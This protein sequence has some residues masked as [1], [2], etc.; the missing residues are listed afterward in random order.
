MPSES[1][2]VELVLLEQYRA[3]LTRIAA[4]RFVGRIAFLFVI[5]FAVAL[6][7]Q[8][9]VSAITLALL[10]FALALS[11]ISETR[12]FGFRARALEE[13]L[14]HRDEVEWEEMYV[15]SRFLTSHEAEAALPSA[16]RWLRIEP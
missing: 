14:A 10:G 4:T 9:L 12:M 5:A 1:H 3:I 13:T 7:R 8:S 2:H 16:G 6:P 11:W 15:R